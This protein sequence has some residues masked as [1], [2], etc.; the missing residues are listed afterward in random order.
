MAR[1]LETPSD[2][3]KEDVSGVERA[4]LNLPRPSQV[5]ESLLA[6][7]LGMLSNSPCAPSSLESIL[8]V[9]PEVLPV[10]ARERYVLV[11][12]PRPPVGVAARLSTRRRPAPRALV[13][14]LAGAA[15]GDQL[16]AYAHCL[17]L[18]RALGGGG[19]PARYGVSTAA[20]RRRLVKRTLECVSVVFPASSSA[21]ATRAGIA[22]AATANDSPLSLLGAL[23][24]AGWEVRDRLYLGFSRARSTWERVPSPA[25]T[26]TAPEGKKEA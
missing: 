25:A 9:D 15:P 26:A 17:L 3:G 23:E 1:R 8:L 14:L 16:K 21:P 19:T 5:H 2:P 7:T 10:F 6:S 20:E 13:A 24:S 4:L 12:E 22:D 11:L 18:D